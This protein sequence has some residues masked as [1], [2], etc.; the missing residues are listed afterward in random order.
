MLAIMAVATGLLMPSGARMLDQ[1]TAH[2]VF[3]E[4]QREVND[5]RRQASRS[6]EPVIVA[7]TRIV[8]DELREAEPTDGA[9]NAI[10]LAL[11]ETWTYEVEPE[12]RISDAGAC[13]PTTARLFRGDE[14]IMLLRMADQSCRFTRLR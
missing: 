13:Q 7:S 4:L 8:P 5:L 3:F 10:R 6:G 11:P 1:A 14:E 12:L 9:T 2:A